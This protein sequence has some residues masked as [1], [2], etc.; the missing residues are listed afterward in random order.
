MLRLPAYLGRV[1]RK[2]WLRLIAT[3]ALPQRLRLRWNKHRWR[4]TSRV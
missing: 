3:A 4:Y 1:T 2:F